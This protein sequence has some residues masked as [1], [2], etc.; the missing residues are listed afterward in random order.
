MSEAI[1]VKVQ[2]EK[3]MTAITNLAIA[4]KKVAEALTLVP[5]VTVEGC[6]FQGG[7]PAINIE[8]ASDE[9]FEETITI[10]RKERK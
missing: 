8:T 2:T 3:R 1:E 9:E 10:K 7:E 5:S 4:V 6:T